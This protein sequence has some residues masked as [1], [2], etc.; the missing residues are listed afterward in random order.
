MSGGLPGP[1]AA[2]LAGSGRCRSALLASDLPLL[3]GFK[4]E[5]CHSSG[6]RYGASGLQPLPEC[7][8]LGE[9][10]RAREPRTQNLEPES[11]ARRRSVVMDPSGK[12]ALVTGGGSG[13]GR[14]TAL[15]LARAGASVVVADIGEDGGRQTGRLIEAAGGK[16][17]FVRTDVTKREDIERMVA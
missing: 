7:K 10:L 4:E 1:R 8:R 14:A 11:H 13:I 2:S 12:V 16:A 6:F 5:G 3:A 9:N 15:A 17:A